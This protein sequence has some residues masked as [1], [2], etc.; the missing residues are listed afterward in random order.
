MT[1]PARER[2]GE[3][4]KTIFDRNF[5]VTNHGEHICFVATLKLLVIT[6]LA[7]S[8]AEHTCHVD[9]SSRRQL[10]PSK[11]IRLIQGGQKFHE[12]WR[13]GSYPEPLEQ[14][15][16]IPLQCPRSRRDIWQQIRDYSCFSSVDQHVLDC[17]KRVL[18]V[19]QDTPHHRDVIPPPQ[20]NYLAN[21]LLLNR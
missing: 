18:K 21:Y 12:R 4:V 14:P 11:I 1:P 2:L 13:W 16:D 8:K 15:S 5:S 7:I 6:H 17:D 19:K 10:P 9:H 20:K 3:L